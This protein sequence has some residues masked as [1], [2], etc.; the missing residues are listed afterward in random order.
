MQLT[1]DTSHDTHDDIRKIIRMLQSLV[2]EVRTNY[3]G[4]EQTETPSYEAHSQETPSRN[5]FD[6]NNEAS[7]TAPAMFNLFDSAPPAQTNNPAPVQSND[8]LSG[9]ELFPSQDEPQDEPDFEPP[10][11][12]APV[13]EKKDDSDDDMFS[14]DLETY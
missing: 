1:I 10:R 12:D 6:S 14:F 3:G 8:Q 2:G 4:S 9:R 5:I 13:S 7:T 11:A